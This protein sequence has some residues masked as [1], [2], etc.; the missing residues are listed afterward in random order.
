MEAA[1][2]EGLQL[3]TEAARISAEP[4]V[5][6]SVDNGRVS[7]RVA[8]IAHWLTRLALGAAPGRRLELG[9]CVRA[10]DE[11]RDTRQHYAPADNPPPTGGV[12]DPRSTYYSPDPVD[13]LIAETSSAFFH[14]LATELGFLAR[15]M[16]ALLDAQPKFAGL[17]ECMLDD[18]AAATAVAWTPHP[19]IESPPP[20][21]VAA[22]AAVD[23]TLGGATRLRHV[24][25]ACASLRNLDTHLLRALV[26]AAIRLRQP[27]ADAV[28]AVKKIA[29]HAWARVTNGSPVFAHT[30]HVVG[31]L[32]ALIAQLRGTADGSADIGPTLSAAV[33]ITV[34][35]ARLEDTHRHLPLPA[36]TVADILMPLLAGGPDGVP[37]RVARM[38]DMYRNLAEIAAL[39]V[40]TT[41]STAVHLHTLRRVV[42]D[43]C[44]P[45]AAG[46][47]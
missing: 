25:D 5:L 6:G 16:G 36:C 20:G 22:T 35:A 40:L 17:F 8:P 27:P 18:L 24:C 32:A 10:L 4:P 14:V 26:R 3:L 31:C 47:V 39:W 42:R 1:I 13:Q 12:P 43:M 21:A 7:R 15:K 9:D 41:G 30:G 37:A 33:W 2:D 34:A 28:P 46:A 45:S 23:P 44:A 29:D 11:A 38:V 19:H